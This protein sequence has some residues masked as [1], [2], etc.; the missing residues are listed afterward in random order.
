MRYAIIADT[1]DRCKKALQRMEE[2]FSALPQASPEEADVWIVVGGDGFLLKCLH[3]QLEEGKRIHPIFGINCGTEGFLLNPIRSDH[4]LRER[5]AQAVEVLLHPLEAHIK[6]QKGEELH[7]FAINEVS[8]LR[9]TFQTAQLRLSLEGKVRMPSLRGDGLLVATP[10]GSTAYNL[11]ARGPILPLTANLLALT[12]INP[13]RPRAWRG[14]L[15]PRETVIKVEVLEA[16]KRPVS[17]SA[18]FHEIY[19][20]REVYVRERGDVSLT[21][22]F[23]PDR[24]LNERILSEQF[25]S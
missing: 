11:S 10:A 25:E 22:L 1:T 24:H 23:D 8:L 7:L 19:N 17:L 2:A 6:T 4:S 18:D 13:F 3:S 14:A 9:S 16:Q 21:L 12:P 15:I 20:V 5:L